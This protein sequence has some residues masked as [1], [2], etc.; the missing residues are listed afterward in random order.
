VLGAQR[1]HD[2][3]RSVLISAGSGSEQAEA[4]ARCMVD[5]NRR[6]IDSH[7]VLMLRLYLPRLRSGAMNGRARPTIVRQQAA[8]ALVDGDNGLGQFVA[9]F[10]MELCCRKATESGAAVVAVCNSN[11]FGA[12]STFADMA[13]KLDCVALVCSNSDPGLAPLGALRPILGTNPLALAGPAG[14]ESPAPSLDIATSVV[15]LARVRAFQSA[16]QRIPTGWAIGPD[17]RATDD[18]DQALHGSMLPMGDHKGFGLAFMIDVLSACLS[19]ASISPAITGDPKSSEP[20]GT[21]HFMM[22]VH[23]GAFAGMAEYRSKLDALAE[24]VHGGPRNSQTPPFQIPG[25]R[26]VNTT[27][28]R[29]ELIPFPAGSLALLRGLGAE[30]G[31]PFPELG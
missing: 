22:A 29:A 7:G 31:V 9:G 20:Q 5:A 16:G 28:E 14:D 13:G 17:G 8:A 21:G 19:G 15:A 10:A 1:L 4:T 27:R 30:F 2:W 25:E 26:E 12:A 11:H 18:P 6:G 23:V 24:A 3:A